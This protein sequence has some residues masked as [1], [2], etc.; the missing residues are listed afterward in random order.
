M[1]CRQCRYLK[2]F[3]LPSSQITLQGNYIPIPSLQPDLGDIGKPEEI[4]HI[5]EHFC[6]GRRRL[7]LFGNDNT[8]RPGTLPMHVV[9]FRFT[10][11]ERQGL[12]LYD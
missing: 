3:W 7:H 4:F 8:I 5:I 11:I 6:L 9:L 12:M 1:E 2:C 10:E